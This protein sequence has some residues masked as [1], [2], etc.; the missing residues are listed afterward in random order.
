MNRDA[1]DN[2]TQEVHMGKDP[3]CHEDVDERSGWSSTYNEKTY[4]FNSPECKADFDRNPGQYAG[5]EMKGMAGEA[6]RTVQEQAAETASRARSRAKYMIQDKKN[7]AADSIGS[8]SVALRTAS[9]RLREQNQDEMANYTDK[10]A[11]NVDKIAAYLQ[12]N[13]A[14]HIIYEAEDFVRRHP[15]WMIGGAL[16]AGFFA[17][18]F[19]KSS[20]SVST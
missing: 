18:R 1:G 2:Q 6:A 12:Q 16:T 13:D 20:Q 9:Q 7:K 19:L 11:A 14:D 4:Y 5:Q 17:A 8:V 3:V 15:A 10:A